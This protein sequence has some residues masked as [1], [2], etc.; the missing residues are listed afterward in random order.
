MSSYRSD[1]SKRYLIPKNY[2]LI[3]ARSE[4]QVSLWPD[5][6]T[7]DVALMSANVTHHAHGLKVPNLQAL[8]RG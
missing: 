3:T 8:A 2:G 4:E 1:L 6:Q 7:P 5:S